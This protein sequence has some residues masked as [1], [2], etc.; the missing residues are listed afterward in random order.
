M[1]NNW[2]PAQSVNE[3]RSASLLERLQE[4]EPQHPAL[5]ITIQVNESILGQSVHFSHPCSAAIW[6]TTGKM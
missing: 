1:G 6:R 3:L 2:N 4:R 5:P